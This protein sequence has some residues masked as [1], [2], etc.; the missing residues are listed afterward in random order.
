MSI[1]LDLCQTANQCRDHNNYVPLILLARL[2]GICANLCL[3]KLS[4]KYKT[5]QE[6][7][8]DYKNVHIQNLKAWYIWLIWSS[9]GYRAMVLCMCCCEVQAYWHFQ[10]ALQ[11]VYRCHYELIKHQ[12]GFVPTCDITCNAP[13]PNA[14]L[15]WS[16]SDDLEKINPLVG[17]T[18]KWTPLFQFYWMSPDPE[19]LDHQN[20]M[21]CWTCMYNCTS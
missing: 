6:C 3:G 4:S 13:L 8:R 9:V 2:L 12:V 10:F 18:L 11:F 20:T 17:G 19:G 16:V 21:Q 14:S 5:E 15:V 1:T 7:G